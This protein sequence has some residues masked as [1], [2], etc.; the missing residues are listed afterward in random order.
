[1]HRVVVR[2]A[3]QMDTNVTNISVVQLHHAY[4]R[5]ILQV[6]PSLG[7]V[8]HPTFKNIISWKKGNVIA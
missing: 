3:Y 4:C 6:M 2:V 7:N 8:T 1:M 5:Y